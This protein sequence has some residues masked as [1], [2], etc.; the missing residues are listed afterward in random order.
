MD[1]KRKQRKVIRTAFTKVANELDNLLASQD[2]T[3]EDL[4]RIQVTW[5]LIISKHDLL[6][7]IDGEI[8]EALLEADATED[9]LLADMESCDIYEKK[10]IDL[11]FRCDS[12]LC[13]DSKSVAPDRKSVSSEVTNGVTRRNFKLPRIEFKKF[14]GNIRDWLSFWSQFRK[15]DEDSNIDLEDKIAYL[16]QATVPGSRARQLVESFPAMGENYD[17]IVNG[18]KSRFG[19]EDLQIEVYIREL[20][21]LILNNATSKNKMDLSMLYD[22]IET[23]LRAL[24]TLGI[25]SD[26]CAAMLFPLI[27][28]CLPEDL[29]RVWQRVGRRVKATEPGEDMDS[30]QSLEVCYSDFTCTIEVLDQITICKNIPPVFYGPWV[31]ELKTLGVQL[32]DTHVDG[33]IELLIGADVCGN[34]YTGKRH[35]LKSG[36]VAV[37][38]RLGWT[39]SGRIISRSPLT[40]ATMTISSLL[41]SD[42]CIT[43]LWRLDVLGITEPS[44]KMS[45]DEMALASRD[46]FLQTVRVDE[47]GRY[48]VRLPWLADHPPL[49]S[50]YN[51]AKRR[52]GATIENTKSELLLIFVRRSYRSAYMKRT[53]MF[54]DSCGWTQM[55]MRWSTA[56]GVWFFGLNSSPFLLGATID[57]HLLQALEKCEL[58]GTLYARDV[59]QKLSKSFYVDN[60]VTSVSDMEALEKFIKQSCLLM[61]EAKF[62]LRGWEYTNPK[63]ED[64]IVPLLGLKWN[65][66]QDSLAISKVSM[67]D[68][69]EL[70]DKVITKRLIL[71]TAQRI[72][73]PIGFT[74]PVTLTPKLLLQQTW[75]QQLSWDAPVDANM[76][77]VFRSWVR[78][79]HYLFDIEIPRWIG[80]DPE[81]NLEKWSLHVFCDASNK[82]YAA[83]VF[84]RKEQHNEVSIHLMAAKARVAP[85]KKMTMPRLEL[86]AATIG[87]R[88]CK[89]VQDDLTHKIEAVLW[90]DSS[91]VISWICRKD[92]WSPFVG[93]RVL[94]IR[95]LTPSESWRHV[96]GNLNPA[97]LTSR[98]CSAKHLFESR[99]WE[100]PSW[101]RQP[102]NQ[103]ARQHFECDEEE[104]GKEKRKKPVVCLLNSNLDEWHMTYFSSYTKTLRMV[105]WIFRFIYNVRNPIERQQGPLTTEEINLAETFVFR[106]V[107]QEVFHDECDKRI[108]TLNPFKDSHGVIRLK[109]RVSNREDCN[110]FRFPVVLPG[111]HTVVNRLVFEQHQKSCHV[112]TQGLMSILREKYWILGGR[113]A[114]RSVIA[115]C[116]VCKRHSAKPPVVTS[117][118]LP[119]DR[120]RDAVAFEITGIDF[121]GP[122][123]LKTE[124]KAWV[125]L[126][127]CAVYRAV[128]LELT[129]SL[130]TASFMQ[131]FR[132]FVARR[133]KVIYSDNGTN[134]VGTENAFS[135]L[136]WVQITEETAV[137]RITWRF[138]PPAAP[139]WGGFWERIV[140]V[141][142]VLLR[143][144]LGRASLYYEELLTLLCDCEA[145]VN[146]RPLTYMSD[147]PSDLI[148]LTPVMFLRD[149][150]ESGFPDCDAVDQESLCKKMRYK[151]KLRQELRRRFRSEY[152]GQLKLMSKG[153]PGQKVALGDVVLIGSDHQKR[154][155]WP[156][157]RVSEVI[158]GKDGLVRL[159]KV[160]TTNGQ[161][162]RPLQRIYPLECISPQCT[163]GGTS[164]SET[165]ANE[166][167]AS[168]A[169][170][171]IANKMDDSRISSPEEWDSVSDSAGVPNLLKL[172][173]VEGKNSD[174]GF[175]ALTLVALKRKKQQ[176]K[177]RR[178]SKEWY[179]MRNRFT[180]ERLLNFLRDSEPEDYRNFLRMNHESFDYLL[181]LVRPDIEKKDTIMRE[182]ISA[183]Q[184]LSITLRYLASGIDLED[185]KFR[186]WGSS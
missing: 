180:H 154:L 47:E 167:T 63:R 170:G 141:L 35:V 162:L 93:N 26:K 129:T 66:V 9:D 81:D 3:E 106:L 56:T 111:R 178:W 76:E 28:S 161:L 120:V 79:L 131:A 123:Y 60:C 98:G 83:V 80:F 68:I 17:K 175:L 122:L 128:H 114:I 97:D 96:P 74:C 54:C 153:R 90:S 163:D 50:N 32:E 77:H 172:T 134:F 173:S 89:S 59:I 38:T 22:K 107:Q 169:S 7:S 174:L 152:L 156:L 136:N 10:F 11:R 88:L 8:Y 168:S 159:V 78:E 104:I 126:F 118:P 52:L 70:G 43:D 179:K 133:P 2:R 150:V 177:K 160:D 183:S 5:E 130:S 31:E 110:N 164:S 55:A 12:H 53:V 72:F 92:D 71:S 132:R 147:D 181:E 99:W 14:D 146:T 95:S 4:R 94:E 27:E 115:K 45:R 39:I 124:E 16:I 25:T 102:S 33:P 139:W 21:K 86:M 166:N 185:L 171:N 127:T 13:I 23:Q 186:L 24:E 61:E 84:L 20:L 135:R 100:G 144:T 46:H 87:A 40:S 182:A 105:G 113:R 19:R 142:K 143:K 101:L 108:C 69:S 41:V 145:I 148:T 119:L 151:Q 75:E 48:E 62:E 36:L 58:P 109:S 34:L 140:G 112:G 64:T 91:T 157:G 82:S 155:D 138:N 30:A 184:R 15:V 18:L 117:P 37:E 85:L 137:Q 116:V 1:I 73:D 6:K 49:P 165:C 65:P 158:P 176:K 103:W 67:K 51:V 57:Y 44:E 149:Q 29:I 42:T 121:A 125:C